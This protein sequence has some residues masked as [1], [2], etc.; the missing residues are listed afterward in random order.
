M[1]SWVKG[2]ILGGYTLLARYCL[3]VALSP[4]NQSQSMSEENLLC[5]RLLLS[6]VY[7]IDIGISYEAA[8]E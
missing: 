7:T 3:V 8:A 4:P 1:H 2:S 6:S 5:E